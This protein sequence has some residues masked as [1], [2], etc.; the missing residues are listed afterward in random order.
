MFTSPICVSV[1]IHHAQVTE[2]LLGVLGIRDNWLKN[3]RDK[4]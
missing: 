3:Y 4:G 1:N 2:A